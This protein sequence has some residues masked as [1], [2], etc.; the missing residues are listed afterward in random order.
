VTNTFSGLK[1]N[2]AEEQSCDC[3]PRMSLVH[4]QQWLSQ[5]E[6]VTHGNLLSGYFVYLL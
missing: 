4:C 3:D 1:N 2:P 6:A 5:N